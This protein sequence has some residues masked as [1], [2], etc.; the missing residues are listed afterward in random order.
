MAA[1]GGAQRAEGERRPA[2]AR[3]AAEGGAQ[4]A[5]GERR[6]AP[7]KLASLRAALA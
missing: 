2:P 3:M 1:E 5:E 6:Q 7:A 4:R